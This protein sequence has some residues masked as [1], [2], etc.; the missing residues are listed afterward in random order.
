MTIFDR[1]VVAGVVA[2]ALV[3][4]GPHEG[5]APN[6]LPIEGKG[7]RVLMIEETQDRSKLPPDQTLIFTSGV[8][9]DY[10]NANCAKEKDGHPA[11][12]IL[13]KD[14]DMSNAASVWK[15]AMKIPH[16]PTPWI[17]ISNGRKGVSRPLPKTVDETQKLI[18]KY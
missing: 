11:W 15:K 1:V 9:A 8:I 12:Y 7:L 6:T 18:E 17:L 5:K 10:L 16:D 4:F 14:T 13:D 2:V 3:K